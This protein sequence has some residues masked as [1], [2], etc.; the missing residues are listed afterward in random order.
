MRCQ[1]QQLDKPADKKW[2]IFWGYASQVQTVSGY[3]SKPTI[4]EIN[5]R[6][7]LILLMTVLTTITSS[8]IFGQTPK[9][10]IKNIDIHEHRKNEIGIAI[11]PAYFIN[12]QVFTF[13][14]HIHYTRN[15]PETKFGV[16]VSFERIFLAPK[17]STFGL[18]FA[19]RPIEKLSFTLSPGVTFEDD[20]PVSLFAMHIETA[21]EFELGE[22]HIGP[23]AELGIEQNGVHY[24]VGIHFG[25]DF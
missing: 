19:Y 11:S 9:D 21:Y 22:F 20:N 15:I 5:R 13:A 4:R 1:W 6:M 2:L 18:V 8:N 14:M 25:I 10:T 3:K 16:G 17:H 12:E 24:M 23:M 7:R